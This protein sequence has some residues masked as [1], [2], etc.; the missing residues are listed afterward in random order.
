MNIFVYSPFSALEEI[1]EFQLACK[2]QAA[3][4]FSLLTAIASLFTVYN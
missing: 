4:K 2:G 1:F 3:L